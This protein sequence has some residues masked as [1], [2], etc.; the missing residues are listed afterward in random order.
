MEILIPSDD[1]VRLLSQVLEGLDYRRLSQAASYK[2]RKGPSRKQ[3]FKIIVYGYMNGLYS[4][5]SIHQA[6]CRDINFMFLLEGKKAPSKSTIAGFR[7]NTP[8]EVFEDLFF[9]L[10]EQLREWGEIGGKTLYVDGTKLEANANRYSFVWRKAVEKNQTKLEGKL[11]ETLPAIRKEYGIS[12]TKQ[13]AGSLAEAEILLATLEG[14][15]QGQGVMFVYGKGKHKAKIQKDVE[16]LQSCIE[17]MKKYAE[18]GE[19]FQ[20]RNSFSKT[21]HDATFMRMKDD[22]MRN[23][24]LKPGYNVQIG[25]DAEYIVGVDISSERSDVDAMIPLLGRMEQLSFSFETIVA[26]AGYESEENYSYLDGRDIQANIKPQNYEKSK[27]R[28]YK[29]DI[30]R[31]ENMAYNE[32]LD[33]YLCSQGRQIV[34]VYVRNQKGKSGHI[35]KVTIYECKSCEGCLDK[36]ACIRSK[37]NIDLELSHKRL[38][39]SKD[40]Q[41]YRAEALQRISSPEGI[42]LRV[43]RSIQVEGVFGAIKED[44]AFRRFLMRGQ[45]KVR[46]EFLFLALGHNMLKLHSKIQRRRTGQHLHQPEAA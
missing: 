15:K 26:D 46:A 37:A 14:Y 45:E 31:A 40:F 44:M 32:A 36:A 12:E 39:F 20:G 6:C 9:Q 2:R 23:G 28:A 5:R 27:G 25:V 18:Y 41:R 17:R 42:L 4:T 33:Y 3:L 10:A 38:Y 19:I 7:S 43:N 29:K 1:S 11:T 21:D 22:Y 8:A 13:E 16:L 35:S 34:P 30:S 24:Q